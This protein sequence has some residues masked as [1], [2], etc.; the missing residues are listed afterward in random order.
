MRTDFLFGASLAA[1]LLVSSPAQVAQPAAPT[2]RVSVVLHD[3]DRLLGEPRLETLAGQPARIEIRDAQGH[4]VSMSLTAVPQAG[5]TVGVTSTIDV[6]SQT[7]AHHAANPT[8]VV[9]LG[10]PAAIAFGEDGGV[11]K[12]FRVDFT[13][14]LVAARPS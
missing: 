13:V 11:Q 4:G 6:T 5:S 8:L 3:G 7:G 12:P 2:Y 14:E 10:E 9:K 1:G